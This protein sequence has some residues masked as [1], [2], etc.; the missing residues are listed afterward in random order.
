MNASVLAWMSA[1]Q[2]LI[3]I[4]PDVILFSAKV[5]GWI[6]DMFSQ[7]VIDADTQNALNARVNNICA[8]LLSGRLP[9]HWQVE[10]DP[11]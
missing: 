5:K 3:A 7:G 8:A 6:A 9:E 1:V 11:E 4:A 10:S 2:G